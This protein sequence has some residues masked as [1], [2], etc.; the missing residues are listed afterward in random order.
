MDIHHSCIRNG[1]MNTMETNEH[2][3]VLKIMIFQLLGDHFP[4]Y[5]F[6]KIYKNLIQP[7]NN[8]YY[9]IFM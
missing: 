3:I 9:A 2:F 4:S 6:V 7:Y 1:M 5:L 8:K